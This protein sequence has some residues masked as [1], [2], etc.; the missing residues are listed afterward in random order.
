M[1]DMKLSTEEVARVARLARLDLSEEKTEIFAGQLHNILSY[2]DKLNEID[3]SNI[4]PM[5]SPVEHT[6][7]LRKDVIVKEHTR[8]E[9][10]S[11]APDTD[12]Q[13]FVVPRIV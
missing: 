8:D 11:N 12:G 7:V 3:T 10:L 6:T 5:F 2:M 13:Y 1:S 4:E 9:I